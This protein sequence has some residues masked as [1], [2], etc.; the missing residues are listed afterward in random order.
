MVRVFPTG[1]RD[2]FSGY[3]QLR[4]TKAD[5]L[6]MFAVDELSDELFVEELFEE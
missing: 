2:S 5:V 6:L 4:M 1:T 3:C